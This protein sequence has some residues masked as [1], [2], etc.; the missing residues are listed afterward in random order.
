ME[1]RPEDTAGDLRKK[2]RMRQGRRE[3]DEVG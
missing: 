1:E 2:A 3:G